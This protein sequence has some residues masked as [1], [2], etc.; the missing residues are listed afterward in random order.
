VQRSALNAWDTGRDFK[1]TILKDFTV[2]KH[3]NKKEIEKCC[4]QNHYLQHVDDIFQRV[5]GK[6]GLK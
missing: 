3:L 2:K 6:K 1:E 4:T 5:F